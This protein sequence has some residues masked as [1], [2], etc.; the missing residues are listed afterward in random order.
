MTALVPSPAKRGRVG[1]GAPRGLHQMRP[2]GDEDLA[3]GDAAE[4]ALAELQDHGQVLIDTR[5][6]LANAISSDAGIG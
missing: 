2:A 4:V 5:P 1:V 3:A 6:R